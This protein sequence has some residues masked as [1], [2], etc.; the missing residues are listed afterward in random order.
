[1]K[2][3]FTNFITVVL[4]CAGGSSV[5]AGE[6]KEGDLAPRF[7]LRD[8]D[9]QLRSLEDY[10]DKWLALYFYPKD[11][12]PGCTT[13]A[14]EFRDAVF[15]FRKFNCQILGISMDDEISHKAFA[16]KYSLPFPLLADTDGITSDIY[17]VKTKILGITFSKRQTFLID[18][19]GRIA[20]HY[21]KV[22]PATHSLQILADLKEL[23]N[24]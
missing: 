6:I 7:E 13:E 22:N 19:N 4:L 9:G 14:C 2:R 8:Q 18:P 10:R 3:I 5:F 20:K 11:D 21:T 24:P 23:I 17:G 16:D 1:M 12:T 15:S